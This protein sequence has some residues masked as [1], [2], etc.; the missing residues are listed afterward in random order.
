MRSVSPPLQHLKIQKYVQHWDHQEILMDSAAA[1][2]TYSPDLTPSDFTCLVI[3]KAACKDIIMWLMRH[4]RTYSPDL[5]PSDFTCL[6]I[7]KVACKDIIMWLMRHCRTLHTSGCRQ[8]TATF[9]GMEYRFFFK[10]GRM[11]T[12]MEATLKKKTI[13]SAIL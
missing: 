3:W 13:L 7:W 12:K 6:V 9:T 11:L 5:T 2:R 1:P 4:C 8:G 10:G